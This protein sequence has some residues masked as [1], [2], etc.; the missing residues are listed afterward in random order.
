[1][2]LVTRDPPAPWPEKPSE[3]SDRFEL[4]VRSYGSDGSSSPQLIEKIKAWDSAGRPHIE[5]LRL[6]AYPHGSGYT[7]SAKEY[8]FEKKWTR[9]VADWA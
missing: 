2:A 7:P 8:V 4:V 3:T 6:R 9:L 5:G 1:M